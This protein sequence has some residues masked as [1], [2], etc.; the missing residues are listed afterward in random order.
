MV[1]IWIEITAVVA[2]FYSPLRYFRYFGMF[3]CEKEKRHFWFSVRSSE[4]V[5]NLFSFWFVLFIRFWLVHV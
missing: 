3:S 1:V 4:L 5:K 2:F